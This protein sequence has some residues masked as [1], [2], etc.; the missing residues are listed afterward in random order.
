MRKIKKLNLIVI[1]VLL[2]LISVPLINLTCDVNSTYNQLNTPLNLLAQKQIINNNE[3]ITTESWFYTKGDQ[4]DNASV[5]A[6]TI[7]GKANYYILGEQRNFE[8]IGVPNSIGSPNWVEFAK[9]DYYLPDTTGIDSE[10]CYVSHVW[11]EKS[12]QF[13]GV[14]WRKNISMSVDMS[15][16]EITSASIEVMFNASVNSNVDVLGESAL[17]QFGIGDFVIFYVLI[18]DINFINSYFVARNQTID[19]GRDTGPLTISDKLI[20]SYSENV[21]ITALNSA[22]EKD[23]THSNFT[24]TLGIDIYSEDNW[25]SDIDTFNSLRIKSCNLNFTYERKITKFSSISCNQ[26]GEKISS[27]SI[28]IT[29][30]LLYYNYSINEIWPYDLS[31]FSEMRVLINENPYQTVLNL[32]SFTTSSQQLIIQGS[33]FTSLF[34]EKENN[35]ISIQIFIAN[36]FGLNRTL[37]LSIDSIYLFISYD[38][39]EQGFNMMLLF[40]VSSVGLG[41]LIIGFSLYQFR[42]KYPPMVRK[43]RKLKKKIRKGKK[44]KLI[45]FNDRNEIIN[46]NFQDSKNILKLEQE[47]IT[48]SK[49]VDGDFVKSTL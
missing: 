38:I 34:R 28:R 19:L 9:P 6:E 39:I 15:D 8:L 47:Q 40:I 49:Q 12:N 42:F 45:G 11:A 25:G 46:S 41:G 29:N 5:D 36:T 22:F 30:A 21:L 3:F 7:N 35:L 37:I 31:P 4:G 32:N 48:K 13:P 20:E 44:T 17:N 26:I 1:L 23:Y 33:D 2:I 16:Y 14:H 43:I 27:K 24:I 10:G 18:S